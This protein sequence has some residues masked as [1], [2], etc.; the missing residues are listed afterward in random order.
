MTRSFL[1]LIATPLLAAVLADSSAAQQRMLAPMA[2]PHAVAVQTIGLTEVSVDYSRPGLKGRDVL[3]D[4]NVVPFD[5][6]ALPWRAGANENTVVSFDRDVTIG[7]T[8]L[9]AGSYGLHIYPRAAAPWTVMFSH[10]TGAWGSYTYDVNEDAAR[11]DVTPTEGPKTEWLTYSFEDL[12]TDSAT[13]MLA[14][15]TLR[16]PI[17]IDVDTTT[18]MVDYL[19]NDYTRGYGFWIAAQLNQAAAWCDANDVNLEEALTWATRGANGAPSFNALTVKASIEEKLGQAEA[20]TA[21]RLAAE[22]LATEVQ[23]NALGYQLMGAGNLDRAIA[24]FK[25]NL[26]KFPNSW[27]AHDS[28]AEAL[29][30]K[31]E[32]ELAIE[33]YSKALELA[34]DDTNRQRIGQVLAGLRG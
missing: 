14:W 30:N 16:L 7:G 8:P 15:D 32:T 25:E 13:L 27:N 31:G 20:A 9:A 18:H 6:P 12:D 21:T 3:N 28:L 5:N 22:P 1:L 26:E 24:V 2:S 11:V 4:P 29:A 17:K 19:H 23:R 10:N 34:P 33:L